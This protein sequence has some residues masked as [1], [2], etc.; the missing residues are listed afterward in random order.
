MLLVLFLPDGY[1]ILMRP[2]KAETLSYS[3]LP[4]LGDMA[5][6]T[7]KVLAKPWV[8]V[9]VCRL[10]LLC[11]TFYS[12]L[13]SDLVFERQQGWRLPCFDADLATFVV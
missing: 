13:L 12:C 2:K 7:R 5:V 11:V 4:L 6:R 1:A 8:G 3:R 9:R 10:L